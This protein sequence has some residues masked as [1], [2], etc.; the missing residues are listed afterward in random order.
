[1][2]A[3]KR[4][5]KISGNAILR[6]CDGSESDGMENDLDCCF[7]NANRNQMQAGGRR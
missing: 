1:M 4:A 2:A 5:A 3:I 6:K 7:C